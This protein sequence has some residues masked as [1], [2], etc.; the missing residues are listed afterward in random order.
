MQTLL[1]SVSDVLDN[2][3]LPR[4][5]QQ[6]PN[7]L[8]KDNYASQ[9]LPNDAPN[10]LLPVWCTGNGNCLFNSIS[11]LLAGHEGL[12]TEIRVRTAVALLQLKNTFTNTNSGAVRQLIHEQ[13]VLYSPFGTDDLQI[14]QHQ[15]NDAQILTVFN[16]E[17]ENTLKNSTWSGM[18]QIIGIATAL[19]M[20]IVSVYPEYNVRVRGIFNTTIQPLIGSS[21]FS[22]SILWSGYVNNGI[23][24][25]NHFVP[26]IDQQ[27]FTQQTIPIPKNN[28]ACKHSI[29]FNDQFSDHTYAK[30]AKKTLASSS[31]LHLSD[32]LLKDSSVDEPSAHKNSEQELLHAN[33]N[34]SKVSAIQNFC[35]KDNVY[36]QENPT[37]WTSPISIYHHAFLKEMNISLIF[38]SACNQRML[39][40]QKHQSTDSAIFCS[41]CNRYIKNM[42]TPPLHVDNMYPG[43]IPDELRILN[44]TELKLVSQV[45]PYM[46][47]L[48]LP[49]GGQHGIK[50][51]SINLPVPMQQIC[52]SLPRNNDSPFV[53]IYSAKSSTYYQRVNMNHIDMA[54]TWLK[55]NNGLYKHILLEKHVLN[56]QLFPKTSSQ[57]DQNIVKKP[58]EADK[59]LAHNN[60][61]SDVKHLPQDKSEYDCKHKPHDITESDGKHLPNDNSESDGKLLPNE[62]Q[63]TQELCLVPIDHQITKTDSN[64]PSA[65]LPSISSEPVNI[66]N[67]STLEELAFPQLYPY[68]TLGLH[69]TRDQQPTLHEYFRCRLLNKDKRWSTCPQYMFWALHIYEQN[70][71]QQEISVVLR[72]RTK[73]NQPVSLNDVSNTHTITTNTDSYMFMKNLRGTSAYWKNELSKLLAKLRTLGPPTFFMSL[74]ANDM[75]WI[76]NFKYIDPSLSDEEISQK[77]YSDRC[78]LIR[79]NPVLCA[80]HFKHRWEAFL[81]N[82]L[83]AKPYP[84]GHIQ[85]YFARIEFQA[86]GTPHIHIFLWIANAPS[87]DCSADQPFMLAFIDKYISGKL[88]TDNP[89]HTKLVQCLQTHSHTNTCNKSRGVKCRFDFPMPISDQTRFKYVTDTG[90]KSRFYILQRASSDVWINPYN[91]DILKTW[92]ANMDIQVVGSMEGA[93]RYVCSYICKNEPFSFRQQVAETIK[94]MPP[95]SSQ[96]KLLSKI[97]NILLTHRTIGLQETAYRLLGLQMVYSSRDTVFINTVLPPKRYRILKSKKQ[98]EQLPANSTNIFANGLPQYYQCRPEV[99][100]FTHMCLAEFATKYK[101]SDYQPKTQ[102][103]GQPRYSFKID[104]ETKQ[105]MLRRTTACLRCNIPDI[106][107]NTE[108]HFFS[109]LYLF[110]PFRNEDELLSPTDSYQNSFLQK[111]SLIDQNQLLQTKLMTEVE[112]SLRY[113]LSLETEHLEDIKISTTP[114]FAFTNQIT[115]T[116]QTQ[117]HTTIFSYDILKEPETN[118]TPQKELHVNMFRAMAVCRMT[119]EEFEE[120]KSQLSISQSAVF[121]KITKHDTDT[122]M[123]LFITGGGLGQVNLTS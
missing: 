13:A 47:M 31:A 122:S 51:Q 84:L 9:F 119:D 39:A 23:F 42:K 108:S 53:N 50:G 62:N 41:F 123:H 4:P 49:A 58:T 81:R 2:Y 96:R 114:S 94:K 65:K 6:Y 93:A 76:D 55:K 80:L 105:I 54:L 111:E 10:N 100:P 22:V 102:H 109:L 36:P 33:S 72:N 57:S 56:T 120:Q 107:A 98:L 106:K 8:I 86:R 63:E 7:T 83:L 121:E 3:Q 38:C 37:P 34:K 24:H 12:S 16:T 66:F 70:R 74:S 78:K 67:A 48:I 52:S 95:D 27:N 99:Q 101:L 110:Y 68:G 79:E 1:Q 113:I 64:I 46:Q 112:K 118:T 103:R 25:P 89:E 91:L 87:F 77:S 59:H 115:S 30:K 85:D 61:E 21:H 5:P 11:I 88:P 73:T 20:S 43:D 104:G 97:G 14:G 44:S 82:F 17:V 40:R 35:T 18:W 90:T 28:S 117:D 60:S 19:Q 15:I 75:H 26:L 45:H 32:S 116:D 71:L 69:H 29:Q 92:N